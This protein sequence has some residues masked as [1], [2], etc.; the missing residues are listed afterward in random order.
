MFCCNEGVD[1]KVA[2]RNGGVLSDNPQI[3][4]NG[5]RHPGISAALDLD[6][7]ESDQEEGEPSLMQMRRL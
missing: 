7:Y 3:G 4:V 2:G 1:G 5:F 6:S